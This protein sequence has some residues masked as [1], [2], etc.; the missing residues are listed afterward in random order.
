MTSVELRFPA[1]KRHFQQREILS[2]VRKR[3]CSTHLW[4]NKEYAFIIHQTRLCLEVN[5]A[6][7]QGPVLS[8]KMGT[9][10]V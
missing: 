10:R 9:P 5:K 3:V 7:F 8:G 2:I 1:V 4:Q 6:Q